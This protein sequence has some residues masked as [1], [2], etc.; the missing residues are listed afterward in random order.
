MCSNN[1]FMAASASLLPVA[2]S[3]FWQ[4][5]VGKPIPSSCAM[6]ASLNAGAEGAAKLLE[7][8]TQVSQGRRKYLKTPPAEQSR[9]AA[10]HD[11]Y[12]CQ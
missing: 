1:Q 10:V 11:R 7:N 2:R 4:R 8:Q 6:A 3:A 9:W 5:T 12:G